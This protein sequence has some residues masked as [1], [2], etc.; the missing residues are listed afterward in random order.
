MN[1]LGLALQWREDRD[2]GEMI[3]RPGYDKDYLALSHHQPTGI[4]SQQELDAIT[5]AINLYYE[6]MES[7]KRIYNQAGEILPAKKKHL[8]LF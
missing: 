3:Q 2:S 5:K 7:D 6:L 8:N 4:I 1:N